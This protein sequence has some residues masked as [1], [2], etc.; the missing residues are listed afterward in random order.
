MPEN[1][2]VEPYFIFPSPL[3]HVHVAQVCVC[4]HSHVCVCVLC[5]DGGPTAFSLSSFKLFSKLMSHL[6]LD[7]L[8]RLL[9]LQ[10][11]S[12]WNCIFCLACLLGLVLRVLCFHLWNK[13]A[14][15][16]SQGGWGLGGDRG[17]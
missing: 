14:Q 11:V 6:L 1:R 12:A 2:V 5:G 9:N 10:P 13:D 3:D 15:P 7:G 17:H 4:A 16:C 8:R